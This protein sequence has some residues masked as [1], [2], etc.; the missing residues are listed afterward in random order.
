MKRVIYQSVTIMQDGTVML[1]FRK[2]VGDADGWEDQ[3]YHRVTLPP[4]GDLDAAVVANNAHLKSM[5]FKDGLDPV[6]IERAK[7]HIL[8]AAS[9]TPALSDAMAQARIDKES[10][11]LAE[12]EQCRAAVN[13]ANEKLNEQQ[14]ILIKTRD[15]LAVLQAADAARQVAAE[16][17]IIVPR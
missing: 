4:A 13:A 2:Q 14:V 17:L 12:I 7:T 16:S 15:N 8:L 11:R 1:Q 10:E 6:E 5:G 3:D 9:D